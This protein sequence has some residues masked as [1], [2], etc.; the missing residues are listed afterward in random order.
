MKTIVKLKWFWLVLWLVAA[1]GLALSAPNM[2]QLVRDKGQIN[3]PDGYSSSIAAQLIDEM[4]QD[5]PKGAQE[6]SAV[7]VFHNDKGLSASEMEEAKSAVAKMQQDQDQYGI[8]SVVSHFDTKELEKNMVS[9]D[10][11][12]VLVL[13][14]VST[15]DRTVAEARDAL[16]EAVKDVKVEHYYTGG[17]LINEDVV[18]S[19][20]EG[21]KKTELIT[22]VFI[23]AIL[24]V[25]FRSVVA[26]FIPLLSVGISYLVAQSVVAFL[27]DRFDFPL[28]NFTQIFM[29]AVMF[30]IGTD[31]CILLI[32]RFKEELAHGHDRVNAILN[33]YKTAGR[34]VFF[35]GFAVLVGFASIGFSTFS[36]YRSAVAVAV[37]VG[38]LLIALVTL[39]PFFMAVLGKV[40]FW[41]SRG[42]LEH[43]QSKLWGV[44]G[45]FSLKRPLMALIVIAVIIVP[46]LAAYKGTPS[47]N[48]LEEIGD[49]YDSV[50]AF[51]AISDSFGPGESMPSKVVLKV[52]QPM[53]N[54]AGL[55]T[56]EQI[57]RE[58]LKVDGVKA[59]RSA[60]RPSGDAVEEFAVPKQAVQLGDG[61]N[62]GND[63]IS[64]IN[65]GLSEASQGLSANA[66]K[67]NEAVSATSKL[68][69]GTNQLKSGVVQLGDGVKEIE[70]HLRDSS[71]G[72]GQL[73]AALQQVKD[74][75]DKLL[76]ASQQLQASY[77]QMG[78]GLDT[79]SK[80]YDGVADQ[81]SGLAANLAG[82]DTGLKGLAQKYPELQQ[83]ADFAKIQGAVTGL[84]SGAV[85][86]SEGL[87]QLN[88]NLAGVSQGMKQ[89]NAGYKQAFDGQTALNNALGVIS[90]KLGELQSG[91]AQLADGQGQIATQIPNVTNGFDQVT[92]GQ[93]QLQSGFADLNSQLGQ[94]TDGLNK[95]TDGL[96][97]ISGGLKTANDYLKEL[98]DNPNPNLSGW[99]IPDEALQNADFQQ[100]L[101]TYMSKDRKIV[102]FDVVFESNPY[103]VETLDKVDGLNAAV[104]RALKGT[105]YEGA[106]YAV[107]GIT[108]VNHDLKNISAGDYSRTVLLMLVGIGLILALMY[109]SIVMPLYILASLLLTYYT[110]LAIAEVIFVRMLGH[111]GISW[112]V[113]FFGF[114]L[115]M[116]L[117]VDYSIFL[118]DR[119]KEYRHM[120]P[121]EAILLAMK[122][123]GGVII[124][125]AVILGGTFAAMLPSGVMS[126]LQIATIVL[127]G[128]T[129]YALVMLPLFVPVMVRIFGE[130]NWWPFMSRSKAV[131]EKQKQVEA[132]L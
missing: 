125:A 51:N 127:C 18:Q 89:A 98:S 42:A 123:M 14:N 17:M 66:P 93:K 82:V 90:G 68:I 114:V 65:K 26:P 113:P 8:T 2:E 77:N 46:F 23:L 58:L 81:A 55:A 107:E 124:S 104:E 27:V 75:A 34:T 119:F 116:A 33:T 16:N 99:Y 76:A 54:S 110:S 121:S 43:K 24:F 3:V 53:D 111:T 15:A 126:L 85:Q 30:G 52:E 96:S 115:L 50:K 87:K 9:A 1:V 22:G 102:T 59:V 97:Q 56:V 21:L 11:K 100:A 64:Q 103:A 37:G 40:I 86:L 95:S 49:K 28:S 129:L 5:N 108:S 7:L 60:T 38:V 47:F 12:T 112:A 94:L 25:V 106:T 74:N 131:Q 122:N 130:A 117:G 39:V 84:Q 31:Y 45:S 105:D 32:S 57:S 69:D 101:D 19:S 63:A 73:S 41:P 35:S 132:T 83:D 72:T 80:T 109:R 44:V 92:S 20:Q 62:Q 4:N 128:L 13:V 6:E 91:L 71:A 70:K 79:L 88:A 36:L 78:D 118:M 10:G 29:V 120:S 61:L 67:L 48:S